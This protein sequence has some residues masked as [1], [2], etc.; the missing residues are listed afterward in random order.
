MDQ[1]AARKNENASGISDEVVRRALYRGDTRP[2]AHY[3]RTFVTELVRFRRPGVIEE[4]GALGMLADIL[5][6]RPNAPWRFEIRKPRKGNPAENEWR[7]IK[8]GYWIATQPN[9]GWNDYLRTGKLKHADH[10]LKRIFDAASKQFGF[11]IGK[12]LGYKCYAAYRTRIEEGERDAVRS[13]DGERSASEIAVAT[14]ITEAY[15]D[16]GRRQSDDGRKV[17]RI[18]KSL[19]PSSEQRRK[20]KV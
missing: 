6:D 19:K 1:S 16:Q 8:I 18:M 12:T 15:D 3:L 20:R 9:S 11:P 13:Y 10:E 14:G 7:N 5:D 17:L 2:M 4:T